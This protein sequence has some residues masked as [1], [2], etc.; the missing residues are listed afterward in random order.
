MAEHVVAAP[1]RKRSRWRIVIRL[2][3]VGCA[4]TVGLLVWIHFH[5]EAESKRVVDQ[6]VADL[7]AALAEVDQAEPG[8]WHMEDIERQ[9][10]KVPDVENGARIV[11]AAAKL[12]PKDWED[13]SLVN[14]VET[15]APPLRLR[16]DQAETLQG[17]LGKLGP[18]LQEA[19][20]LVAYPKGRYPSRVIAPDFF[21]TLIGDL[22]SAHNVAPL[23]FL[24]AVLRCDQGH[25]RKAWASAIATLHAGAS[26]GDEPMFFS[27]ILQRDCRAR[28]VTAM[29]RILAQGQVDEKTLAE[30]RDRLHSEIGRNRT[31]W[32]VRGERAG[33]HIFY[34]NLAKGAIK[35][36]NLAKLGDDGDAARKWESMKARDIP[37]SHAYMLRM[38]TRAVGCAKKTGQ[39]RDDCFANWEVAIK[40]AKGRLTIP[41]LAGLLTPA[42]PRV[43]HAEM[44]SDIL[45][46]CAVTALAAEQFRLRAKRWPKE[47]AEL[48]KT[49]L[50]PKVPE[51]FDGKPLHLRHAADGL[52]VY[53]LVRSRWYE[54]T[55]WD[56]LQEPPL[57]SER[58][59]FRLWDPAH[60]R[61]PAPAPP[62][63]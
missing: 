54:G 46:E 17:M 51:D 55:A 6:A 41:L 7:Q 56:N 19:R 45:L 36:P 28:A 53:S 47:L 20:K 22:Q 42:V 18:A 24:D 40:D 60:R 59:E 31:F 9:R 34:T 15:S 61:Q 30:T 38:L 13:E 50:L 49:G 29:E 11:L 4:I 25:Y 27:V 21:N 48:L 39:Q 26:L 43:A 58:V 10:E 44:Q 23:L 62:P 2:A 8:G 35:M 32:A 3:T 12:L 52:V 33:Q 16:E 63:P 57:E 5:Q 14:A 1:G 37:A